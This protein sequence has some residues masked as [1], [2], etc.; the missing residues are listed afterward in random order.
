M[1]QELFI[2]I[3]VTLFIFGT[4]AML[5]KAAFDREVK[6]KLAR[7]GVVVSDTRITKFEAISFWSFL[8]GGVGMIIVVIF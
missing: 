7:E 8:I 6:K 3:F 4:L 2:G 1:N 5:L